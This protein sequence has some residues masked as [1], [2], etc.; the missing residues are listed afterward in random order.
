MRDKRWKKNKRAIGIDYKKMKWGIK[1]KNWMILAVV[2]LLLC[3]FVNVGFAESQQFE[4]VNNTDSDFYDLAIRPSDSGNLGANVL[5]KG[6]PIKSDQ[7]TLVTFSNYDSNIEY[8]DVLIH[9]CCNEEL[10]WRKLRIN[11]SHRIILYDGG[12]AELN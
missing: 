7:K 4:V 6:T 10:V 11:S 12:K 8:W 3:G 9:N 1:M 5:P 2:T